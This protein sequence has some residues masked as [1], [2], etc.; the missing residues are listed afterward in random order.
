MLE[1]AR[2]SS[3]HSMIADMLVLLVSRIDEGWDF[4]SE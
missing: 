3:V 1:L 2:M 4:Q